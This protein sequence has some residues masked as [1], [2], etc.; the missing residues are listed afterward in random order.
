M[1]SLQYAR[2]YFENV[3]NF[4]KEEVDSK[5][6]IVP[7]NFVVEEPKGIELKVGGDS[8]D[9]IVAKK[10]T[11]TYKDVSHFKSILL[12]Q[13]YQCPP[14]HAMPTGKTFEK[15]YATFICKYLI[16]GGIMQ[17]V[18]RHGDH[19]TIARTD[20]Y[21]IEKKMKQY[22][23]SLIDQDL[24]TTIGETIR[25][26]EEL[27]NNFEIIMEKICEECEKCNALLNLKSI[28]RESGH[29][30]HKRFMS[31]IKQEPGVWL[32]FTNFVTYN[33]TKNNRGMWTEPN[34]YMSEKQ[35]SRFNTLFE[36]IGTHL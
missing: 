4:A 2:N 26:G 33:K 9:R 36:E 15:T 17:L 31:S 22:I 23:L 30:F 28:K 14:K 16:V 1:R 3:D 25:E 6:A 32:N 34:E 21:N 18:K 20:I 7:V 10:L 35:W 13:D 27:Y 24:V 29:G 8:K 11:V 5:T 12:S 19:V